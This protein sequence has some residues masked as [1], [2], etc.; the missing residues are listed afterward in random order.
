MV[1]YYQSFKGWQPSSVSCQ[2]SCTITKIDG[3]VFQSLI[4][5]WYTGLTV[6]II[7][8]IGE[9]LCFHPC[10]H[11]Q[12][13][14]ITVS[15]ENEV[16]SLNYPF[17]NLGVEVYLESPP[18]LALTVGKYSVTILVRTLYFTFRSN[19]LLKIKSPKLLIHFNQYAC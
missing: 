10:V 1:V 6:D 14:T 15:Y 7:D 18:A 12:H 3:T 9:S 5:N 13:F 8:C 16:F 19:H 4:H 2:R 17:C 11:F